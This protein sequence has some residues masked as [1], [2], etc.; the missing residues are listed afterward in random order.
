V[1]GEW[2]DQ[3]ANVTTWR[4][5]DA[6]LG[7]VLTGDFDKQFVRTSLIIINCLIRRMR[8]FDAED[9]KLEDRHSS[10]KKRYRCGGR[11]R[12]C[13]GLE[14][15]SEYCNKSKMQKPMWGTTNDDMLSIECQIEIETR[16]PSGGAWTADSG[17]GQ[18]RQMSTSHRLM[19]VVRQWT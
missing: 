7:I 2:Y 4:L 11:S 19:A 6:I 18:K 12:R 16:G 9:S 15:R 3:L 17:V 1:V 8:V 5:C 10:T 14:M 13:Q